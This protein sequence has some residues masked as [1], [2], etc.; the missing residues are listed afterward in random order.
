M[1]FVR[2][3]F[4]RLHGRIPARDFAIAAASA[5]VALAALAAF[6]NAGASEHWTSVGAIALIAVLAGMQWR[7]L[8]P[9][10]KTR[11]LSLVPGTR[12]EAEKQGGA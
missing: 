3:E 5:I 8:A 12:A 11:V 7:L 9:E 4:K 2:F 1:I 10:L 6:V